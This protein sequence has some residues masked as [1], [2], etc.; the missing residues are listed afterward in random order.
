MITK[1]TIAYRA[2]HRKGALLVRTPQDLSVQEAL[3]QTL[4]RQMLDYRTTL[5]KVTNTILTSIT[6][7][8]SQ[9]FEDRYDGPEEEITLVK[10]VWLCAMLVMHQDRVT[11]VVVDGISLD[12]D[13]PQLCMVINQAR[14][15]NLSIFSHFMAP[16]C[17]AMTLDEMLATDG[18]RNVHYLTAWQRVQTGGDF[19]LTE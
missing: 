9:N 13:I 15:T 3:E 17:G 10:R 6:H 14:G 16:A 5:G 8:E 11:D 12:C 18:W 2:G 1:H 7:I 4:T 19:L